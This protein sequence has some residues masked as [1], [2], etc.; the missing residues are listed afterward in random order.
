MAS[1]EFKNVGIDFPIYEAK[2]RSLKTTILKTAWKSRLAEGG[3]GRINIKALSEINFTLSS[4]D[5]LGLIGQNGAGKSTL[6]R[7]LN[8][9]YEPTTGLA[10]INGSVGSLIDISLGIDGESTG[11]ENI[12]LR[13]ALLGQSRRKINKI[14]EKIIDFSELGEFID[15]PV[16]T[17]SSGMNLR[18][19]FS[20][21]SVLDSEILI[22]DEWLSVGDEIFQKKAEKR[23]SELLNKTEILIIASHSM[24]L[25][26]D[27]CNKVIW[28]ESGTIKA[29]GQQDQ[30]ID[31]YLASCNI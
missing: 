5:R 3:N 11:R 6:L 23:I 25:I 21:A 13:S 14:I 18:L 24:H 20:I 19:A 7:T 2:S 28:L 1:I 10:K 17:Y 9:V 16:R 12:Y 30:I 29:I 4:G 22:M 15:M 8:G 31:E 27:L 26:R